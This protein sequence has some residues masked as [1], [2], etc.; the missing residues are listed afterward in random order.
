METDHPIPR[1]PIPFLMLGV[2]F[3]LITALSLCQVFY[4]TEKISLQNETNV[5]NFSI[6]CAMI[7]PIGLISAVGA[8]HDPA[9]CI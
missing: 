5:T 4:L 9:K 7:S 1:R 8:S 6:I 2:V 3:K